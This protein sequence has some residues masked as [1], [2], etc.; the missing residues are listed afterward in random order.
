MNVNGKN[1]KIFETQKS[2]PKR[3]DYN[4]NCLLHKF[5]KQKTI[6]LMIMMLVHKPNPKAVDGKK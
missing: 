1:N 6:D 5:E 3:K 4:I 2:N